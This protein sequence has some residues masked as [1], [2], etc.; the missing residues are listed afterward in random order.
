MRGLGEALGGAVLAWLVPG[1]IASVLDG[2]LSAPLTLL[3]LLA[4]AAVVGA[5]ALRSAR[6]RPAGAGWLG[7]TVLLVLVV[8]ALVVVSMVG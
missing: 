5:L 8:S 1:V 3:A 4:M 2:L 7:G 6:L